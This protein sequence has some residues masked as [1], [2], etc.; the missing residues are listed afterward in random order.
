MASARE[1]GLWD[2]D[3]TSV[4]DALDIPRASVVLMLSDNGLVVD[5]LASSRALSRCLD[6]QGQFIH[7]SSLPRPPSFFQT[8]FGSVFSWSVVFVCLKPGKLKEMR[9]W[10]VKC[11]LVRF[12]QLLAERPTASQ[13]LTEGTCAPCIHGEEWSML[14]TSRPKVCLQSHGAWH[15]SIWVE[16]RWFP[17]QGTPGV[18]VLVVNLGIQT[19]AVFHLTRTLACSPADAIQDEAKSCAISP[20]RLVGIKCSDA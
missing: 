11:L 13:C 5:S 12:P 19:Q 20:Q 1:H 17:Q 14:E 16:C 10:R 4:K 3:V 15:G 8:C 7:L 2:S 9:C 6:S 18:L